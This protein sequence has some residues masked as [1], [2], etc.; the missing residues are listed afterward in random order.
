SRYT[1]QHQTRVKE[2][3]QMLA[4]GEMIAGCRMQILRQALGDDDAKSCGHCDLC[5]GKTGFNIQE[6]TEINNWLTSRMVKIKASRINKI[7]EGVAIL[8]GKLRSPMFIQFMRQRALSGVSNMGF[9]S[10]L[11]QLLKCNL[12]TLAKKY[13]FGGVV[14][15]PSGTWSSRIE[16]GEMIAKEL[17]TNVYTDLLI[18]N[19]LPFK[20]QGE[21]L[22]NDQRKYNVDKKMTVNKDLKLPNRTIILLDDYIG[23]G[24][25]IKEAARA[26]R[27][28]AG[29]DHQIVPFT[30]AAIK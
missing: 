19:P 3:E 20:R 29:F 1:N 16:V 23:S 2:L 18:W 13:D 11:L 5:L 12:E 25:T 22:N 14:V 21:L 8:D 27:K 17:R 6:T 26:L 4:Y 24:V 30:I 28:E 9:T 15:I 10:E 7:S